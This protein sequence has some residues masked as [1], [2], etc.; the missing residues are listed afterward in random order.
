MTNPQG[1]I[2]G[3][4]HVS[5]R[6]FSKLTC[7]ATLSLIFV[8]G[9]VTSTGSGLSVP[10]WP[11]S[12]GTVFPPMVGGIRFE[13]THRMVAAAVGLLM[14]VLAVW[15]SRVEKRRW[16]RNLSY[17]ALG[18][19]MAQGILGGI[20]VLFFLPK[21]I[22]ILHAVFAQTF[23]V[24]TIAIAY[25]QSA[26]RRL[27]LSTRQTRSES[28]FFKMAL[29]VAVFIYGQLIVG[30]LMRHTDSGLAIPDFPTAG[31]YLIPRFDNAMLHTINI[32][33]FDHNL[34]PVSLQQ[35]VIHYVHRMGAVMVFVVAV[36]LTYKA[37][38]FYRRDQRIIRTICMLDILLIVQLVLGALTVLSQRHALITSLHVV[39]GAAVLGMSTLLVF[40]VFPLNF[41]EIGIMLQH[42][43]SK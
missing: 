27:R 8:G 3:A 20:T 7:L 18:A 4:L 6:R 36:Y 42:G 10:D 13:H 34:R 21:P 35:V 2:S 11:L 14:F 19:V 9:L 31:G 32:W 22:S 17:V 37:F 1:N 16:V 43:S 25:S 15:L 39:T 23:F 41:Q 33:R 26:E 12:Y 29:I 28:S 30:A 24:L 38:C 5:L 40:Q